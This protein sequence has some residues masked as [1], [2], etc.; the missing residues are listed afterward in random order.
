MALEYTDLSIAVTAQRI[1][2]GVS[3]RVALKEHADAWNKLKSPHLFQIEPEI[4]GNDF[5]DA[6]LAASAEY[7]AMISG[8]EPPIWTQKPQR[9]L[10]KPVFTSQ[11]PTMKREA[12]AK[13]PFSWRRRNIFCGVPL[14]GRPMKKT[15]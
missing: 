8:E 1:N 5:I 11:L 6:Y 13:T 3:P 14:I 10:P 15:T 7:E 9:F 4:T 2:D 12:F